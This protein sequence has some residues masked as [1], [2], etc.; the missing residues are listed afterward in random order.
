MLNESGQSPNQVSADEVRATKSGRLRLSRLSI[1]VH[2]M[3]KTSEKSLKLWFILGGII[4]ILFIVAAF[5]I[6]N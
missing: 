1:G 2:S 5:L 4:L 3:P 6:I